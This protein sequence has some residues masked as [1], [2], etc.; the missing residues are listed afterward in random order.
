[1]KL[2]VSFL[3]PYV[4]KVRM[5]IIEKGLSDKVELVEVMPYDKPT[6]LMT[7]NPLGK[8]PALI[9][10]DGT[11]LFDS[12]VICEYLDSLSDKNPLLPASGEARIQVLQLLAFA[13]GITDASY[14][15]TM[16]RRRPE[17]EQSDTAWQGMRDKISSG[18]D[19]LEKNTPDVNADLNLG[20][21][22]LAASLGYIDLRHADMNW[23]DGRPN[24]AAWLEGMA[25]RESF[26]ETVPPA[27]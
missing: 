23:R 7:A 18:L 13:D 15:S 22:G 1:M 3:S 17:G 10:D 6:D 14:L 16:E 8:I 25:K 26:K 2:F 4:R 9:R 11:A 20:A 27:Q 19:A 24:L 21:L 5:V 12:P